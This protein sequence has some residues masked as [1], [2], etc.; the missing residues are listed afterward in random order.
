MMHLVQLTVHT[1]QLRG[2]SA[3]V[4]KAVAGFLLENEVLT[5]KSS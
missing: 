2:I 5:S 1:H 4:E 3:N